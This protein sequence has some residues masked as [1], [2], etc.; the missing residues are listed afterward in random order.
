MTDTEDFAALLGEFER[1]AAHRPHGLPKVGEKV[2]G[3]ILSIGADHAF[4]DLGAKSEGTIELAGLTDSEGR[5]TVEVGDEIEAVVTGVDEDTGTLVLGDQ[6]GRQLRGLPEVE[7]AYQHQLPV[8]GHV[9]GATKGGLELQIA[10]IRAFCPAA[11]LDLRYVE[12]MQSFVGQRL[13][14][15][16]TKLEGGKRPNLVVSRRALLEEEQRARAAETRARLEVGAILNGS[17]TSLQ[18]YGAFVDLG[19]VEGMI[20]ISE[21]AFR[22]VKHPS[23]ILTVGQQV[24]VAVLRIDRT[25]NPRHPEKIA[26]SLRALAHDPWQDAGDRFPAGAQVKGT[27]VRLQPFGAFVELEPGVEGLIHVSELGAGRRVSHPREVLSE[28]Q[29]V[30]ATVLSVDSEKRRIA[31]SLAPAGHPVEGREEQGSAQ[32]RKPA[33]GFGTLGDL[34]RESMAKKQQS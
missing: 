13:A 3:R 12:D 25:D 14:F 10:G 34:L 15:R 22:H 23:E 7:H 20:H 6:H 31:L 2:R 19:G 17:V 21:L 18:D 4:V 28:G 8:E 32:Y 30:T 24:E 26:L 29:D 33:E 16:I 11:Q 5:L 27:I 9:T 1:Q